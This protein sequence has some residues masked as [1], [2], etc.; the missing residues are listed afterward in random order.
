MDRKGFYGDVFTLVINYEQANWS[1]VDVFV[2]KYGIDS[3]T[4]YNIYMECS[5]KVDGIFEL[6]I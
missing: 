5:K 2:E 6:L 3:D 4:L 1:G